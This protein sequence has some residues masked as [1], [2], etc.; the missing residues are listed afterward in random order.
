MEKKLEQMKKNSIGSEKRDKL[1]SNTKR[2]TKVTLGMVLMLVMSLS[3]CSCKGRFHNISINSDGKIEIEATQEYIDYNE[4][5]ELIHLK[6]KDVKNILKSYNIEYYNDEIG[7]VTNDIS[8]YQQIKEIKEEDLFGYYK[9]LGKEESEKI[10]KILGYKDWDDY[11]I[12]H[13]YLDENGNPSIGIWIYEISLE[14]GRQ[15]NEGEKTR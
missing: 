7:P 15:Y 12:S 4:G 11:L 10:I 9:L 3:M 1:V 2:I 5:Y 14:L 6:I 13:S 8:V